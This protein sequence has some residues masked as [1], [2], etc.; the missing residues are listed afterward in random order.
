MYFMRGLT[1]GV[2][3][4]ELLDQLLAPL[5][6]D[7]LLGEGGDSG[8]SEQACEDGAA[9]GDLLLLL[10]G[11][12]LHLKF[13]SN[14]QTRSRFNA[15]IRPGHNTGSVVVPTLKPDVE[16]AHGEWLMRL[17]Q[18]RVLRHHLPTGNRIAT[19]R[20]NK[21]LRVRS[22]STRKKRNASWVPLET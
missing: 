5:L 4:A 19:K 11:D 17:T 16:Q 6:G 21:T 15:V 8:S 10:L 7:G 1:G 13:A 3:G 9:L 22:G 2:A 12:N 18:D 14:H 20:L